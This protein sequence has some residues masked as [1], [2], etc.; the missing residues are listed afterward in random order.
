M[1][2]IWLISA[3]LFGQVLQA[4]LVGFLALVLQEGDRDTSR[5]MAVARAAQHQLQ[6]WSGLQLRGAQEVPASPETR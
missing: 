1:C 6:P 4:A 2:T 3:L 5:H